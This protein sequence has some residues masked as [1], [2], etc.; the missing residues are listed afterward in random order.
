MK[1]I[2]FFLAYSLGIALYFYNDYRLSLEKYHA[3]VIQNVQN[4]YESAINTYEFAND[5]FHAVYGDT[6]A[7][8]LFEASNGDKAQQKE[9]Q[10]ELKRSFIDFY[11]LKRQ[12][13][14]EGMSVIDKNKK[15]FYRFHDP[16]FSSDTLSW[17]PMVARGVQNFLYQKG[18]EIDD[19]GE[20]Y[21]F[22]YP[23]FW[24]GRYVGMYEYALSLEAIVQQMEKMYGD[25]YMFIFDKE[26][27]EPKISTL[28][29]QKEYKHFS[30]AEK[31]YV[32]NN[33]SLKEFKSCGVYKELAATR[34]FA[35][36]LDSLEPSVIDYRYEHL[37]NALV[38]VP[39]KELYGTKAGYIVADVGENPK[40]L[41]LQRALFDGFLLFFVG[42][43]VFYFYRRMFKQ[44]LYVR[45]LLDS[46]HQMLV[47]T[48][49]EQ[50]QDANRTFFRFFG[51]KDIR[52]FKKEHNCV[53][54][55]FLEGDGYLQ[56]EKN[57]VSWYDFIH[58]NPYQKQRVKMYDKLLGEERIFEVS[59]EFF[60][61]T[62]R[63]FLS[64]RDVTEQLLREQELENKAN[65]DKLTAIY[66]R[67]KFDFFLE[68]E[69]KKAQR[70]GSVFSLIMFDIDHFKKI[71]DTYGHDVGDYVLG[72]IARVVKE[73]TRDV[74]IFARWGG[75]EF[76]IITNTPL[77]Q[78]Q[79]LAQKLRVLIQNHSFNYGI[80]LTCSFGVTQ[81][82]AED[83]EKTI[84]KRVDTLLYSAKNHG[85][86]CVRTQL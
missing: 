49:G 1:Y 11:N 80:R 82:A 38:I 12:E 81:F 66:N 67:Q 61:E 33:D 64:F 58:D 18:L 68:K 84:A 59:F 39:V 26:A 36:A 13:L 54:D 30:I 9:L 63:T 37:T 7:R 6:I 27:I 85:R 77:E 75:E 20:A 42:G 31:H 86:N 56:K 51:Y 47:I 62:H 72:E 73:H 53:C 4:A 57:G 48:D 16:K 19:Y 22:S 28:K 41:Y 23:L 5:T 35:E 40:P 15:V 83:S 69:I 78:A 14:F 74:D 21:R 70:Y 34:E 76:M 55:F 50:L 25:R 8:I 24:D 46:Q 79:N 3:N 10:E 65:F 44:Q 43:V 17:R 2:V 32:M 45:N 60:E 52:A 71:N 29:M